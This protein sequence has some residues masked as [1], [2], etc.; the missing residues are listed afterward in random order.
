MGEA[1]PAGRGVGFTLGKGQRLL[2]PDS[3]Q[4]W[5]TTTA[6]NIHAAMTATAGRPFSLRLKT[7]DGV[8]IGRFNSIR[9]VATPQDTSAALVDMVRQASAV[10]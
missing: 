2:D 4:G 6:G 5:T 10:G 9:E 8:N 1:V 3:R 7:Y